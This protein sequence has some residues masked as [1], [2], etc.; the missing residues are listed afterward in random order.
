MRVFSI[1]T[2]APFL[3]TLIAALIDGELVEGFEARTNPERLVEATLYLPTRRAG[4]M[5]RDVFLDVLDGS[6]H[7]PVSAPRRELACVVVP[8]GEGDHSTVEFVREARRGAEK[9]A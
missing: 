7:D 6:I 8:H 4:R 3:R 9:L 5:A 2:S 1:P